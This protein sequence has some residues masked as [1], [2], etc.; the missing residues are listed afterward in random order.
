MS[1]DW[2][3]FW[4]VLGIVALVIAWFLALAWFIHLRRKKRM[5]PSHIQLYFE[6][7]FRGIMGEWDFVTRDRVKEFKKDIGKRLQAVGSDITSLEKK[8]KTLEKRMGGLE[9]TIADL[10]GL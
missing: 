2:T 7:N 6:E 10:E 4:I 5:E 1:W 9:K 8:R 3:T